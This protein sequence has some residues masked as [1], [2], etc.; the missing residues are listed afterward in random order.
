MGT[1]F[2]S[3]VHALWLPRTDPDWQIW[4]QFVGSEMSRALDTDSMLSSH[5]IEVP[6]EDPSM[7]DQVFDALSYS[8]GASIIRMVESYIG[9]DKF[10]QGMRAYVKRHAFGNATS[11]DLWESLSEAS[12]LPLVEAL[13]TWVKHMGYPVRMFGRCA[14]WLRLLLTPPP[15]LPV[16][17][18]STQVLTVS[19][20]G[21]V[22]QNRFLTTGVAPEEHDKLLWNVPLSCLTAPGGDATPFVSAAT[23]TFSLASLGVADPSKFFKLN[24][25]SAAFVRVNYTAAQWATIADNV[26]SLS[27]EDKVG[28][29]GDAFAL[30]KSGQLPVSTVLN[31]YSKFKG[32]TSYPV[33]SQL[34]ADATS[35]ADLIEGTPVHEAFK[36]FLFNLYSDAVAH[37]GGWNG[38]GA[39]A[40]SS[41]V[42]AL[43]RMLILKAASGSATSS[44]SPFIVAGL[45]VFDKF[46]ADATT[47]HPDLHD[48]VM[49][50]GV[51]HGG[52]AAHDKVMAVFKGTDST[53]TRV[54]C[55]MALGRTPD[56]DAARAFL[57]WAVHSEDVRSNELLYAFMA[58]G[59]SHRGRTVMWAYV[60]GN[61]PALYA[62][63]ENASMML[64]YVCSL[65]LRGFSDPAVA[66]D[67][68]AFFKANPVEA[69]NMAINRAVEAIRSKA[70]WLGRDL[71]AITEFCESLRK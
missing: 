40:G 52:A 22:T 39:G 45:E 15:P 59:T 41:H 44:S 57:D 31:L 61:W 47:V 58:L 50:L 30:S 10:Q 51:A 1:S 7:I 63:Y 62:K 32:E 38:D 34:V 23:R 65:P 37:V 26:S 25:A 19:E 71:P 33:W 27:A 54:K 66:D 56:E 11:N 20:D 49:N 24:A 46:I 16:G 55:L 60:K 3:L 67:A 64:G 18:H 43:L 21:N 12:G 5:P 48:V 6:I 35:I 42:G 70:V 9:R 2:R 69:A 13:D 4:P 68:E 53:E 14:V 28:L 17:L 36:A 29:L 8:K